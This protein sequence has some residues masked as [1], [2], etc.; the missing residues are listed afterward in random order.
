MVIKDLSTFTIEETFEQIRIA[1]VADRFLAFLIDFLIFSPVISLVVSYI[2]RTFRLSRYINTDFGIQVSLWTILIVAVAAISIL[3]N[4]IFISYYGATPGLKYLHLRIVSFGDSG[5]HNQKFHNINFSQA[6]LRSLL[7]W[8][9]IFTFGIPFLE[10]FSHPLRRAIHERASDSLVVS[11]RKNGHSAPHPL[12][13]RFFKSWLRTFYISVAVLALIITTNEFL[14]IEAS[15][16]IISKNSDKVSQCRDDLKI[17]DSKQGLDQVLSLYLVDKSLSNCLQEMAEN[18]LWD[19]TLIE[20]SEERTLARLAMGILSQDRKN[21]YS[22]A[23]CNDISNEKNKYISEE[24]QIVK[25]L[26]DPSLD[27]NKVLPLAQQTLSTS[28]VLHLISALNSQK[29]LK[30]ISLID[31]LNQVD[32]YKSY[33]EPK[34]V[35]AVWNL[36]QEYQKNIRSPASAGEQ[37]S[38]SEYQNIINKFKGKYGFR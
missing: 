3:I 24:C 13:A 27:I 23:L 37:I 26:N 8:V 17:A 21:K 20:S 12:E 5:F 10:I 16:K 11:L 29:W 31:D 6:F 33:L 2:Y 22:Q 32:L 4:A 19:E 35:Q 7:W 36:S 9:C 28:K 25:Y 14:N 30:A 15:L 34:Y 38:D 18:T 1:S